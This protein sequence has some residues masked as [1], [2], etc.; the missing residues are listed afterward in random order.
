MVAGAGRGIRALAVEREAGEQSLL[1]DYGATDP[2]EFFAVL[3]EVFFEQPLPLREENP[4]LYDELSRFFS[5]DPA[6][7]PAPVA[8]P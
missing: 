1:D 7:W 6:N 2:A 8:R 3:A 5:V 4:V